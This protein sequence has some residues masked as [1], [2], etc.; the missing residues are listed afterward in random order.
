MAT[1]DRIELSEDEIM[2]AEDLGIEDCIDY[3]DED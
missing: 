2:M 1:F 3:S